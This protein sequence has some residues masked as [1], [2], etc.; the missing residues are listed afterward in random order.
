MIRGSHILLFFIIVNVFHSHGQC[1]PSFN[2]TQDS[3]YK[4]V[5]QGGSVK[6]ANAW[7][8]NFGDGDSALIQNPVHVYK[9]TGVFN[10]CL[11]VKTSLNCADTVCQPIIIKKDSCHADFVSHQLSP[12]VYQFSNQST[13][14]LRDTEW[15]FDD[16]TAASTT[17]PTH[18][19]SDTGT[20]H[21]CLKIISKNLYPDSV[22]IELPIYYFRLEGLVHAGSSLL[23]AGSV[24]LWSFDSA[25]VGILAYSAVVSK[26]NFLFASIK[27]GMYYLYAVPQDVS[28]SNYRPTYYGDVTDMEKAHVIS[29]L[30]NAGDVDIHLQS[31]YSLPDNSLDYISVFPNPSKDYLHVECNVPFINNFTILI[32]ENASGKIVLHKK[33]NTKNSIVDV[34]SVSPGMYTVMLITEGNTAIKKV[35]ILP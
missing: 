21:V 26:G 30:H 24:Q 8:W 10:V 6:Y 12:F 29:I 13:G 1:T 25:R 31:F 7:K 22:C 5:F 15:I 23:N 19:F 33:I 3:L 28:S 2:V 34:S 32:I 14:T 35:V 20:Y 11:A 17:N 18:T 9:D 27:P 16:G 4:I